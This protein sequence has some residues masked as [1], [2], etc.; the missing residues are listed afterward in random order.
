MQHFSNYFIQ[1]VVI[2][3]KSQGG[4]GQKWSRRAKKILGRAAPLL[5][6]PMRRMHPKIGAKH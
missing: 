6:A 1:I 3:S 2:K 5:P 4:R